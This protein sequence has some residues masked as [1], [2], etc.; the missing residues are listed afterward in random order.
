MN[1]NE[2]TE[3]SIKHLWKVSSAL[4]ISFLSM[5]AMNFFDRLFLSHYSISAFSAAASA[6]TLYWAVCL[7]MIT[8]VSIGEVFVAQYNGAQRY[9]KLGEPIWQMIWLSFF[10]CFFFFIA[11][12]FGSQ[13]LF[14][15]KVMNREEMVYLKYNFYVAP[16]FCLLSAL[17]AFFIGQGQT[18]MIQWLGILG[19]SLNIILDPLLIFGFKNYIPEMGIGGAALATAMGLIFQII[20]LAVFFFASY[21]K[22]Y[23]GTLNW[24]FQKNLFM[25]CLKIGGPPAILVLIEMSGWALFY[26][27]MKQISPTHILVASVTQSVLIL[28]V[29][30]GLALEKGSATISGNLI[31]AKH[32]DQVTRLFRSGLTLI[33]LFALFLA[34]ALLIFPNYFIDW[35]LHSL[36][37]FDNNFTFSKEN[38]LQIKKSIKFSLGILIFYLT[39]ENI[40][41]VLCGLLTSAGDTFYI[42]I[43]GMGTVWFF[44]ILPTYFFVFKP[45][46]NIELAFWIW[47]FYSIIST[48][49]IYI[50][51]AKG[52]WKQKGILVHTP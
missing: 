40:R 11:A 26:T 41:Y 30:F 36:H 25:R 33:F 20:I 45:Q 12:K 7:T 28:L 49:V 4:M 9:E 29:F 23:H 5:V 14:D 46:A 34:M 16:L 47:L 51:F 24:K 15:F 35:F 48:Y 37:A 8:L 2:I 38:I 22:K 18:K 1:T 32:F 50:R 6:G 13:L 27:M 19:N 52:K 31:G 3:G 44:M 42:M 21:Q 10:S 43:T 17:S 39:F